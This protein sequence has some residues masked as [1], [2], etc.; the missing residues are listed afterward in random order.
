MEPFLTGLLVQLPKYVKFSRED[1][2][3]LPEFGRRSTSSNSI[4]M[5]ENKKQKSF[6]STESSILDV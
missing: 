6:E 1:F 3:E 4:I 5:Q 2:G